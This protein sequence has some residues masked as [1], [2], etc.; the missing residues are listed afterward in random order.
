MRTRFL[1]PLI[2][3]SVSSAFAAQAPK[4]VHAPEPLPGVTPEMLD[5]AYWIALQ[6][7]P[8]EVIMSP[9]DIDRFNANIRVR[10]VTFKDFYGKPDPLQ[11][12]YRTAEREGLYTNPILPLDQP[13]ALN[14][15][16]LKQWLEHMREMLY[17]STPLYGSA[18]FYD[19]RN[20]LWDARMKDELAPKL[21]IE[22]IPGTIVREYGVV[23]HQAEM[24]LYPT[25]IPAF[26][27]P[28]GRLDRFQ[29]IDMCVGDPVCVLH[30]SLEGDYLFVESPT[31]RGWVKAG[32]IAIGR[33][34]EIRALTGG[35]S[36]I[37]ARANRVPVYGDSGCRRFDRWLYCSARLPLESKTAAGYTVTLPSR[38]PDGALLLG[39]GY[40][41]PDAD[42]SI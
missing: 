29:L 39:R 20:A 2:V 23:I 26:S 38:N 18:D 1:F 16:S 36:F 3:L 11:E 7:K 42:V 25:D 34:D 5:P 24:R 14:D 28:D 10:E 33:R 12:G 41:K 19:H 22:G 21:N 13:A 4:P 6:E 31:A 35:E 37:L 15:G 8:D 9:K 30:Q 17:N 40:L 32:D 27:T